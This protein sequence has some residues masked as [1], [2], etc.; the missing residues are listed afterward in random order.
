L[1]ACLPWVVPHLVPHFQAPL[2]VVYPWGLEQDP[3]GD[4][5]QEEELDR[6]FVEAFVWETP[7]AWQWLSVNFL[8]GTWYCGTHHV[9]WLVADHS[10]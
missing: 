4:W 8:W 1:V 5:V 10:S 2:A 3:L 6:E 7:L 9:D